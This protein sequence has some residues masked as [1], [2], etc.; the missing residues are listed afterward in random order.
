MPI[1]LPARRQHG[2]ADRARP[3]RRPGHLLPHQQ[4]LRALHRGPQVLGPA[5]PGRARPGPPPMDPRARAHRR[6]RGDGQARPAGQADGA[7]PDR[8]LRRR[9]QAQAALRALRQLP[10]PR[11]PRPP[12]GLVRGRRLRRRG[13]APR[14]RQALL[15][16][17]GG[18][19]VPRH[20]LRRVEPAQGAAALAAQPR[21]PAARGA[22]AP[23]GVRR[24]AGGRRHAGGRRAPGPGPGRA[25]RAQRGAGG[26]GAHPE[27][28]AAARLLDRHQPDH[29]DLL[30][31]PALPA[32]ADAGLDHDPG[33]GHRVRPPPF[34]SLLVAS[35]RSAD[36]DTRGSGFIMLGIAAI[37]REI[38]DP[39]GH[40]VNDL[41]LDRYCRELA[42]DMDM[43]AARPAPRPAAFVRAAENKVLYP[44]HVDAYAD[45]HGK[46]VAD[47]RD[48]LRTKAGLGPMRE[49][50]KMEGPGP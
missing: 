8:G 18:D 22:A 11:A 47:I 42:A 27:H 35:L 5:E 46:S 20:Q 37:G 2:A 14:A 17:E 44:M 31:G 50:V 40:D 4:R 36:T 9:A 10:G 6:R 13:R 29:L 39:F 24:V 28:A 33:D 12:P 32:V 25:G 43:I 49:A 45:W 7:Q 30:P 19:R 3:D 41:P 38:E 1:R 34:P 23:G 16:Q 21:Q 26:H 15:A 48:A